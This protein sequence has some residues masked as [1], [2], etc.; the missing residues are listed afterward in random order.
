[1]VGILLHQPGDINHIVELLERAVYRGLTISISVPLPELMLPALLV[2]MLEC[3][4]E[5]KEPSM[6]TITAVS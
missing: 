6:A 2:C 3:L 4:Q 1:M 5:K